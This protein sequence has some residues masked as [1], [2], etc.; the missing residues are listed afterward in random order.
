M[1]TGFPEGWGQRCVSLLPNQTSP[2]ALPHSSSVCMKQPW[3]RC[4][5]GGLQ[6][7]SFA[8]LLWF[9]GREGAAGQCSLHLGNWAESTRQL[10][11]PSPPSLWEEREQQGKAHQLFPRPGCPRSRDPWE[12]EDG[13]SC[14]LLLTGPAH[15]FLGTPARNSFGAHNSSMIERNQAVENALPIFPRQEVP[16]PTSREGTGKAAPELLLIMKESGLHVFILVRDTCMRH[17]P[18]ST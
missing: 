17:L 9:P 4:G 18:V 2:L 3:H 14:P 15:N 16:P 8:M 11:L 6:N 5:K 13:C 12:V 1:G 7:E 10:L